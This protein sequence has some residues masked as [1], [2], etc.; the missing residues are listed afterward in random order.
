MG[1]TP[2]IALRLKGLVNWPSNVRHPFL[3][4]Y[5][6]HIFQDYT[7]SEPQ[8]R[9]STGGIWINVTMLEGAEP[10]P[11]AGKFLD[12]SN[13]KP[14]DAPGRLEKRIRSAFNNI[15]YFKTMKQDFP[16][17]LLEARKANE[18]PMAALDI[19]RTTP[20]HLRVN[21]VKNP[22][23][24]AQLCANFVAK[25]LRKDERIMPRL[26]KALSESIKL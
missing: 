19:H 21:V 13:T 9:S 1:R 6:K 12:F 10:H 16:S 5:V 15:S 20:I 24:D 25:T 11:K 8:I 3:I 17:S 23:M 14:E 18:N 22:L 26:F 7:I 2:A 4:Q